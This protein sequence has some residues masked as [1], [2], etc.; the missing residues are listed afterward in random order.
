MQISVLMDDSVS[1]ASFSCE[2]GLSLYLT[3]PGHKVLFDTGASGLFLENAARLGLDLADV[4]FAVL[5]HGH[6][7][8]GGGLR[9]FLDACPRAKVY[10]QAAAL[11]PHFTRRASGKVE[12]IGLDPA[13]R[14]EPRVVLLTG[15]HVLEGGFTIFS[16]VPGDKLRP[17]TQKTL[18]TGTAEDLR[19]DPFLHEQDLLYQEGDTAVLIAGCAHRGILNILERAVEL[20]GRPMDAVIGGFHLSNPR[21]GGCVPQET[22][23]A[24]A[25]ALLRYPGTTYYTCHCTGPAGF[26]GL[27]RTMGDRIRWIGAGAQFQV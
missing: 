23:D 10:M 21:D 25:G 20:A 19:P 22:L 26:E 8:H 27:K 9:A 3:T 24:I 14:G 18:L 13:L 7:D 16:S 6:N 4:D 2:H 15:D 1:S 5:S 17:Q 11:E 12:P